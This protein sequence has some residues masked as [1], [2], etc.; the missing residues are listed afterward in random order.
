MIFSHVQR[1]IE[2]GHFST[3]EGWGEAEKVT[4]N[5]LHMIYLLEDDWGWKEHTG[6]D[7]LRERWFSL[8][9]L[10]FCSHELE[11][12][13]N[14]ASSVVFLWL[15][16]MYGFIIRFEIMKSKTDTCPIMYFKSKYKQF[17]NCFVLSCS[18]KNW[19]LTVI[20]Y[21]ILTL[22]YELPK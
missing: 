7:C 19:E 22:R 5:S 15:Y 18:M 12:K 17:F 2:V 10:F 1:S 11:N 20:L 21:F 3:L 9:L 14:W 16:L 13:A 8:R 6:R 4:C